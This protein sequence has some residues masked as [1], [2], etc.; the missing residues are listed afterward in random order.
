MNLVILSGR[1]GQDPEI[2]YT[3]SGKAVANFN[4]AVNS[5]SG[6]KK[7]TTWFPV[8]AWGPLAETAGQNLS[9]GSFITITG[10]LQVREWTNKD[11]QKIKTTEVVANSFSYP[12]EFEFKDSKESG[13]RT[14]QSESYQPE[15]EDIPF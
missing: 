2:K 5:G 7:T 3:G 13:K 11:N 6:D 8:V 1:L 12:T 9:K 4:L 14:N 10:R 15:D